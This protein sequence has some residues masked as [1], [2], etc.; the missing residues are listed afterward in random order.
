LGQAGGVVTLLGEQP[1]G[2]VEDSGSAPFGVSDSVGLGSQ[3]V[4]AQEFAACLLISKLAIGTDLVNGVLLW[5]T[6]A[7]PGL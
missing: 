7:G 5:W 3:Y 2:R 1:F 6:L 4:L